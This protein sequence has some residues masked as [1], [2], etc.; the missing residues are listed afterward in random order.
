MEI[1]EQ[2]HNI[3]WAPKPNLVTIVLDEKLPP[4]ELI[5]TAFAYVF[6]DENVLLTRN[7]R[8]WEVPGGH[9]EPGETPKEAAVRETFEETG[10][11][12]EI[13]Q[14]VG[15]QMIEVL[16]SNPEGNTHPYPKSYQVFFLGRLVSLNEFNPQF[17]SEERSFVPPERVIEYQGDTVHYQA[18][19][20]QH[21]LLSNML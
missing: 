3:S 8:G 17:E 10:A 15:Y 7:Q 5:S 13:I 19:L 4:K 21:R 6:E 14:P 9:L 2:R 1:V 12:I 16:G 18:A 20:K 11:T